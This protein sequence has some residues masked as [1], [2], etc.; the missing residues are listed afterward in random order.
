MVISS[1]LS[2]NLLIIVL[3]AVAALANA[4]ITV[5]ELICQFIV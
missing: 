5:L 1:S 4:L 3:S 2:G